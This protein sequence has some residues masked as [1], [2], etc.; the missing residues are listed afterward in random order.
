MEKKKRSINLEI[1][2]FFQ[3]H[4]ISIYGVANTK[5][6][7][8]Y[9]ECKVPQQILED[10]NSVICYGIPIPKGII[11]AK[12]ENLLQ[13][14]RYCNIQYRTLDSITNELCLFFET[15]KCLAA[16]IYSC[17]PWSIKNREFWGTLPLVYWAEE[18]GLGRLSK[19]GLLITPQLGT[20]ILLGGIITTLRLE[21]D[22]KI[23]EEICPQECVECIDV[24][25]VNAIG[26]NGKVDHNTCLRYSGNNPLLAL[27]INNQTIKET[28]PFETL[29]NTIGVD[30]HGLYTCIECI[31]ACPLNRA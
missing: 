31:K 26:K 6:Q 18:A 22:S 7:S 8:R 23:E 2:A 20:R 4:N 13:Y 28:I 16:P 9:Q 10:A 15:F 24:C 19:C 3:M 12:S 17:F 1:K 29:I 21:P 5:D 30:D 11:Y 14:W 25:P 27:A